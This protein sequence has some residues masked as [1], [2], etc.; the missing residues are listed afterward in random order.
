MSITSLHFF[1]YLIPV[2]AVYYALRQRLQNYWLLCVSY[3]FY[4]SWAWQFSFTLLFLTIINYYLAHRLQGNGKRQT[5]LLWLGITV[6]VGALVFFRSKDWFVP[7]FINFLARF[8]I[9]PFIQ[10]LTVI[11][12]VGLAYYAL[13]NISYL[14]DV[15]RGQMPAASDFVDFALYLAYFPK[16]LSG[17]IERARTFLPK[18]AQQRHVDNELL[19]RSFTLIMI[20][21][22]RKLFIAGILSAVIF[23]DAFET[24]AKYTGPE[25][26]A[27]LLIYGLFL[28]NDFAGYTDIAR[29][30]S[31]L[32]GLEL[33]RNFK[34][35]YFARNFAEFWNSWHIS[36]SHWLRD[37]VYFPVGRFLMSH[38]NSPRSFTNLVLPPV[39]T[40]LVSGLWH[41]LG[42]QMLFWGGMHGIYQAGERLLSV[43]GQTQAIHE[44]PVW[45]Q[46]L[47]AIIVII[48]VNITWASFIMPPGLAVTYWMGMLDWTYPIIRYRR[49]LIA[50]LIFMM[51]LAWDW[52]ERRYQD[53]VF[54][55]RG[56]QW[57]QALVF[58]FFLFILGFV[59]QAKQLEPFIYQKF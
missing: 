56:P 52:L 36:L 32:F 30:I 20:G 45:R 41:G 51:V 10:P 9:Q 21:L 42:W 18:L 6:N 57:L 44:K 39:L 22:I 1:F 27:W 8:G 47:S 58:A 16:L 15:R 14:V 5:A 31:G 55:L 4:T 3:A 46:V 19:A 29:G 33:S 13:Q 2:L 38:T 37:Y 26:A 50:L 25:L 28:Y 43:H 17:P 48:L 40:M 54:F 23:W 24:P 53:E 49:I 11:L 35:P 59:M 7:G 12:P 34:F